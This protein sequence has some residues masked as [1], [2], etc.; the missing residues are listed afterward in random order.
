MADIYL[1]SGGSDSNDGTT[2]ALAKL[3]IAAAITAA[4]TT[5]RILHSGRIEGAGTVTSG[6]GFRAEQTPGKARAIVDGRRTLAGVWTDTGGADA[7]TF[8]TTLSGST[9]ATDVAIG[10]PVFSIAPATNGGVIGWFQPLLAVKASVV[11]MRATTYS[12]FHDT[13][14]NR[15][16]VRT[17][18]VATPV[19]TG[20]LT[21]IRWC[22]VSNG[23]TFATAATNCS[24]KGV[25][26]WCNRG[27]TA[28]GLQFI[29]PSGCVSEDN[30]FLEQ[31]LHGVGMVTGPTTDC[32]VRRCAFIGMGNTGSGCVFHAT[33]GVITNCV[34]EDNTFTVRPPLDRTGAAVGTPA[35]VSGLECHAAGSAAITGLLWRRNKITIVDPGSS[36]VVRPWILLDGAVP[37][38]KNNP[39]TYG[40]RIQDTIVSGAIN[41]TIGSVANYAMERCSVDLMQSGRV[42]FGNPIACTGTSTSYFCA[43]ATEFL[44]DSDF[45]SFLGDAGYLIALTLNHNVSLINCTLFDNGVDATA[46]FGAWFT[47]NDYAT[48]TGINVVAHRCIF[49]TAGV[50]PLYLNYGDNSNLGA[51][52]DFVDNLYSPMADGYLSLYAPIDTQAEWTSLVDTKATFGTNPGVIKNPRVNG[53]INQASEAGTTL[54]TTADVT[55]TAGVNGLPYSGHRGA[56]QYGPVI[57]SSRPHRAIRV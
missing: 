15:L 35:N 49:A 20:A 53:D 21:A 16:Y 3:T 30:V 42:R 2:F 37:S 14:A 43:R 13:G 22:P 31:D 27:S 4:G 11:L 36:G 18:G 24:V 55:P 47:W 12:Y 40:I 44:F 48:F 52:R 17:D 26:F 39:D 45:P 9:P 34:A 54:A 29:V 5:G 57:T 28:Y 25:T 23:L 51:A 46:P 6:S 33:G 19:N 10:D 50:K 8:W 41:F 56:W 32:V 7:G 1:D 38:D